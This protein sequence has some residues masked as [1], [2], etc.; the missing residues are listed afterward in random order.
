MANT[1]RSRTC[2]F[3]EAGLRADKEINKAI[4]RAVKHWPAFVKHMKR[5]AK[6]D[7]SSVAPRLFLTNTETA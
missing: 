5:H 2:E 7:I 1:L 4:D 3:S 6:I